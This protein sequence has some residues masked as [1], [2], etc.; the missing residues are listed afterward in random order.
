[1]EAVCGELCSV[2]VLYLMYPH[3]SLTCYSLCLKCP[4]HT[5]THSRGLLLGVLYWKVVEF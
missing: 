4:P 2:P 5:H 3:P 1:M